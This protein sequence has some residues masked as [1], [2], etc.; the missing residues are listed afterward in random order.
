MTRWISCAEPAE[1]DSRS[2]GPAAGCL[3][4]ARR[5]IASTPTV[6]PGRV[7]CSI[8]QAAGTGTGSDH[9][10]GGGCRFHLRATRARTS[11]WR[12]IVVEPG[13]PQRATYRAPTTAPGRRMATLRPIAM[14]SSCI[15]SG[16]ASWP[17]ECQEVDQGSPLSVRTSETTMRRSLSLTNMVF[18]LLNG[19]PRRP[20]SAQSAVSVDTRRQSPVGSMSLHE[21]RKLSE[22]RTQHRHRGESSAAS[23]AFGKAGARRQR[24]RRYATV[25]GPGVWVPPRGRPSNNCT[26]PAGSCRTARLPLGLGSPGHGLGQWG[27]A[28]PGRPVRTGLSGDT[29]L[30]WWRTP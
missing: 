5:V 17:Q 15:A 6:T 21:P 8:R 23:Q 12:T 10:G 4:V 25:A 9:L 30:G 26:C 28:K 19:E 20:S 11:G 2:C 7:R 16:I 22:G 14:T 27:V 29:A 1:Q 18:G 3:L 13:T 24:R